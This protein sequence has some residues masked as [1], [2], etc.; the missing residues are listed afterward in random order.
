M[1]SFALGPFHVLTAAD[2]LDDLDERLPKPNSL[3]R[4]TPECKLAVAVAARALGTRPRDRLGVYVGQQRG[5]L[6]YCTDFLDAS[7]REGPRFASPMMFSES[8]A[9]IAATHLSLTLGLR[10]VLATFIGSRAAGIQAVQAARED[11]SAGAIDEGLVVVLQ[12][13]S[14]RIA[15][16]AYNAIYFPRARRRRPPEIRFL[17]GAAAFLLRRG[18]DGPAVAYAG[19]LCAG[20][21]PGD[22]ARAVRGLW[23]DFRRGDPRPARALASTFCLARPRAL[24][25]VRGALGDEAAFLAPSPEPAGESFALDP[26]LQL[27]LDARRSPVPGPRAVIAL[28]EEGTAALLALDGPPL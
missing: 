7:W 6:Q 21:S 23:E 11:L 9:N 17:M 10:H 26:F 2:P 4:A 18:G 24:E 20:G 8:V 27:L 22:Q 25:I 13:V 12:G 14:T 19:T 3:R 1:T 15:S 28:S 16:D 5:S